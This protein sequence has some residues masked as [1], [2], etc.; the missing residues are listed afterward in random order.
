VAMKKVFGIL[1]GVSLV[2]SLAIGAII[3]YADMR[4]PRGLTV[5]A[6]YT[7][8]ILISLLA[9]SRK[10]TISLALLFSVFV[11]VAYVSSRDVGVPSWIVVSDRIITVLVIWITALL[12]LEMTTAKKKL[13]EIGRLMTICMWTKQVRV[14]G[15][16]VSIERYLTDHVGVRLTHS[17]SK[18]AAEQ[19]LREEGIDAR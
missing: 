4:T 12:G 3:F 5:G 6:L 17:I 1:F 18:E 13:R 19:I 2:T 8:P 7:L 9:D 10:L 15:E 11:V 16:W 14:D